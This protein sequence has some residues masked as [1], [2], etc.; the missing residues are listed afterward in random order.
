MAPQTTVFPTEQGSPG[1]RPL[2][3][4]QPVAHAAG[5]SDQH[6]AGDAGVPGL[7]AVRP[8]PA[9]RRPRAK[10]QHGR[11]AAANGPGVAGVLH[12]L[13]DSG[14]GWCGRAAFP[15]GKASGRIPARL[16]PPSRH[17]R[18]GAGRGGG[19][20][21]TATGGTGRRRDRHARGAHV[22]RLDDPAAQPLADQQ[23][24]PRKRLVVPQ[25]RGLPVHHPARRAVCRRVLR[26]LLH[27]T[28]TQRP[29]DQHP[30]PADVLAG[31]RSHL[32]ARPQCGGPA[33]GLPARPGQAAGRQRGRRW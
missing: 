7:R 30:V 4:R 24:D 26:L 23:P 2:Q 17:G 14:A 13:P 3:A 1:H 21:R 33:P 16:G 5:H 31:D 22:L 28:E 29:F 12:R 15:L 20:C 9:N 27:R 32:R 11:S 25:D 19:G 6:L 18:D 8:G 10:R